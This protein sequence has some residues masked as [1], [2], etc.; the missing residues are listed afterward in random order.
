MQHDDILVEEMADVDS[1]LKS[2]FGSILRDVLSEE[3]Q[4]YAEKQEGQS[5]DCRL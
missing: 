5:L 2:L 1:T 3:V 4:A